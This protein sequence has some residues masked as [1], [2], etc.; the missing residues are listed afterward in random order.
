MSECTLCTLRSDWCG[1]S[2]DNG[3]S[4]HKEVEAMEKRQYSNDEGL[5]RR[6]EPSHKRQD[7]HF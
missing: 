1:L 7:I 6:D 3:E 2:R 4:C 5:V